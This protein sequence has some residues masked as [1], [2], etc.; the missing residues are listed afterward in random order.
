MKRKNIHQ[1]VQSYT[2]CSSSVSL[3]IFTYNNLGSTK[4]SIK[5]VKSFVQLKTFRTCNDSNILY[6]VSN[7]IRFFPTNTIVSEM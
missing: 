3:R 2:C 1:Y 6:S 5:V 4:P 7:A